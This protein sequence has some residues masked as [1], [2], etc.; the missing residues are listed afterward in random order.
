LGTTVSTELLA[1]TLV[2]AVQL[3]HTEIVEL[4]TARY[5]P[6]E[7]SVG[8]DDR[9]RIRAFLQKQAGGGIE[10]APQESTE[11]AS[12]EKTN[13]SSVLDEGTNTGGITTNSG[14]IDRLSKP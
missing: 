1:R 12:N 13:S 5:E 14:Q 2:E 10:H 8:S 9:V 3:K 7:L 6:S 4:L 11:Q